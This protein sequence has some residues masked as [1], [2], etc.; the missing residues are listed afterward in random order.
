M[1][2]LR[3]DQLRRL[4]VRLRH[5]Y[6]PHAAGTLRSAIEALDALNAPP[7]PA[8]EGEAAPG[9][10][11]SPARNALRDLRGLLEGLH[12]AATWTGEAPCG[13]PLFQAV[14][15]PRRTPLAKRIL[16]RHARDFDLLIVD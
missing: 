4:G 7:P 13:E 11:A 2:R 3:L 1:R 15:R 10:E 5:P 8:G 16:R 9:E 14:P 6:L 12:A